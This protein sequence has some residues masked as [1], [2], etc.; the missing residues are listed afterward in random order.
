MKL[1]FSMKPA[2]K[3]APIAQAPPP[4]PSLFSAAEEDDAADAPP[5]LAYKVEASKAMQKRIEKEK[6]VDSTVYDYDEVWERMQEVKEKQ[7]AAKAIEAVERKP[8]Y[9][10]SLLT[11][12][13][14]RKLDHLR[15]EEKMMQR[16]RELEGDEFKDK[17]AFVTQ[18]YKDQLAEVR[19]AEEEEKKREE[20]EKKRK[21]VGGSGMSHFYKKVLE[22]Q[23]QLHAAAM[24]AS[25]KKVYGPQA[26]PPEANLTI[27][28]P[29]ELAP[30]SDIELAEEARQEGKDVEVN[31]EGQIVDKRELLAAGLNLSLPNTRNLALQKARAA[32]GELDGDVPPVHTAVGVAASRKEINERRARE[33][34]QQMEE[35]Q[36]RQA[37]SRQ[38]AE[39]E[40]RRRIVAKRN[41]E[42]DV[43]SAKERYLARKRQ[44]LEQGQGEGNS[45]GAE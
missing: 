21:G 38:Q 32:R 18:A 3:E 45:E 8:K 39:E 6:A 13:A 20:E 11:S 43:M 42:D 9:I 36:R 27:S 10:N 37:E 25:E 44:R 34:R 7:K 12:A 31:D 26:G 1:S 23:E 33:V 24:A 22:E 41:N 5:P 29:P 17:E 15:A 30:K 28:K 35:E 14:T 2:K 40:S 4:K 19:R 16:E